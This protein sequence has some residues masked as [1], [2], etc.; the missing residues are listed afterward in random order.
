MSVLLSS[1]ARHRCRALVSRLQ[2]MSVS[3]AFGAGFLRCCPARSLPTSVSSALL[4]AGFRRRRRAPDFCLQP[5]SVSSA[6]LDMGCSR[7]RPCA[8]S[9]ATSLNGRRRRVCQR[10]RTAT[11][12]GARYLLFLGAPRRRRRGHSAPHSS[13]RRH[14]PP[15]VVGA[16]RLTEVHILRVPRHSGRGRA[17]RSFFWMPLAIGGESKARGSS[18]SP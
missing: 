3:S 18:Y 12:P 10:C 17:M 5:T 9:R 13:S 7:P 1:G 16:Q 4:G 2:P 15:S 8:T 11:R 6:L 14:P